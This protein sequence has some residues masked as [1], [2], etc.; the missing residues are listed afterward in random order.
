MRHGRW[1]NGLELG[2]DEADD[3]ARKS[4][5]EE[6]LDKGEGLRAQLQVLGLEGG[7]ILGGFDFEIRKGH[8][9][10]WLRWDTRKP[11]GINFVDELVYSPYNGKLEGPRQ[12]FSSTIFG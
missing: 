7:E 8:G 4:E 9:G 1:K 10:G 6:R 5:V 3:S 2:D 11:C 12:L